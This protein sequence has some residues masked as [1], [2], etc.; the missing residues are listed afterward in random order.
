MLTGHETEGLLKARCR[1]CGAE[2]SSPFMKYIAL[3][4]GLIIVL[5]GLVLYLTG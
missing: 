1:V 3:G 4:A 5:G 2:R